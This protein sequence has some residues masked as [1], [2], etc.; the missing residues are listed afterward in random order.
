MGSLLTSG[1]AD[2]PLREPVAARRPG[3]PAPHN[4][5]AGTRPAPQP[6]RQQAGLAVRKGAYRPML[7]SSMTTAFP[8]AVTPNKKGRYSVPPWLL[9]VSGSNVK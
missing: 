2:R 6:R 9:T 8:L 4:S 7:F 1:Q 3:A 5:R